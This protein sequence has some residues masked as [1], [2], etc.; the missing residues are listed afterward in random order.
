MYN[1]NMKRTSL[2]EIY[3]IFFIIGFQLLGGGYVI[4]PLL[5]K[6]IVEERKWLTEEELI[7]YFA[8][9]QCIPGIIANNIAIFAG[10]KARRT[11]GALMAT[12]GI[13]TPCFICII[14]LATLLT[15]AVEN[16]FVQDAFWGIRIAVIVLI[17]V[18]IKDMWAKSVNS[19]FTYLLYFLIL[20]EFIIL[21]VSP[22]IIIILSAV[23]ALVY[24]KARG[25]NNA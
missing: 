8:V 20:A 17:L 7:D 12:L 16:K 4:L 11:L 6:Y 5:Q 25:K 1:K 21:P 22:S 3:K 23:F 18:T 19:L 24:T 10:Y 13:V 2:F 14:S 9:S 15:S